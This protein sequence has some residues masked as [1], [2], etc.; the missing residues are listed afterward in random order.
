MGCICPGSTLTDIHKKAGTTMQDEMM[1]PGDIADSI[2]F[3]L[4]A[5]EKGHVQLLAQPAFFEEWK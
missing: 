3:M 1:E 5:P 4:A 2:M